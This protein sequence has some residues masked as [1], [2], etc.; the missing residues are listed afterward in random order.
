MF[1]LILILLSS[2]SVL[3]AEE[4]APTQTP[5]LIEAK[6]KLLYDFKKYESAE[7]IDFI[8]VLS[9]LS[10]DTQ[11]YVQFRTMECQG[12]FSIVEINSE[13]ESVVSKKKLSKTETKLCMLELISFQKN[14]L[15]A[16]FNLRKKMLV[17]EHAK[18]ITKLQSN[19]QK[20]L[21]DLEK[22]SSHYK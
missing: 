10:E 14:Y 6:Q 1:Y 15:L 18:Q 4:V 12:E 3:H 11:N 21:E 7:D 5:D 20:A 19:Q 16:I 17:A 13:G 9:K 22:I 8:E 2:F